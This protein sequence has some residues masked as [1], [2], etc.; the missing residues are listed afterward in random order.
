MQNAGERPA[1]RPP[2]RMAL[3][4]PMWLG[5]ALL[6][7]TQIACA[8]Y[9]VSIATPENTHL[10]EV[11]FTPD[12]VTQKASPPAQVRYWLAPNRSVTVTWKELYLASG[13]NQCLRSS[14]NENAPIG[15]SVVLVRHR[16]AL[17]ADYVDDARFS[18][19]AGCIGEPEGG[20][21]VFVPT[22]TG[23]YLAFISP[24]PE[25]AGAGSLPQRAQCAVPDEG[26]LEPVRD[27]PAP[28]DAGWGQHV[29]VDGPGGGVTGTVKE[30]FDPKLRVGK[31]RVLVG[32]CSLTGAS[33]KGDECGDD[34]LMDPAFTR[35]RV[36]APH[37]VRVANQDCRGL[38][39]APDGDIDLSP[40]PADA[41]KSLCRPHFSVIEVTPNQLSAESQAS[42]RLRW[43]VE[44][45]ADDGF[46]P[47]DP[48]EQVWIE[49]T[50]VPRP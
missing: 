15:S 49:F 3:E 44:F 18:A 11:S 42:A 6:L 39:G 29:G 5:A 37:Y 32:T 41:R 22:A 43:R 10:K 12:F 40:D 48:S 20:P 33:P 26:A 9:E 7:L 28:H 24:R 21:A 35:T 50:L 1:R 31:V 38:M 2:W 47:P 17:D 46:P 8:S 30:A 16:A 19:L 25:R 36:V 13:C 45:S 27:A 23:E 4:I 14:C 34:A